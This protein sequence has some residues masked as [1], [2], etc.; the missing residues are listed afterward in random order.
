[1]FAI[2]RI[3]GHRAH[4]YAALNLTAGHAEQRPLPKARSSSEEGSGMPC[5]RITLSV[6]VSSRVLL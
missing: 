6:C 5:N 3:A 4:V 1:M 2:K